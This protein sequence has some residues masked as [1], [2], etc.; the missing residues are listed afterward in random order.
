MSKVYDT[1]ARALRL[2]GVQDARK[3]V[4]PEDMQTG[5]EALN[6]MC[7]RWE[8][9]GT[10]I[11]WSAVSNP[12]DDLPVMDYQRDAIDYCLALQLAP[13]Y[14]VDPPI[15]VVAGATRGLS[16]LRRDVA[17]ASL[18]RPDGLGWGRYDIYTDSYVSY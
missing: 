4:K 1:V 8:A 9:N 6:S 2:I 18:L 5:I 7:A 3:P 12:N 11:G 16:E 10:S 17:V 15:A 14:L 13:E